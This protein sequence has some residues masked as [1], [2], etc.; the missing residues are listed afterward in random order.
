MPPKTP[1][2]PSPP[3]ASEPAPEPAPLR[4]LLQKLLEN[5]SLLR[6]VAG[7][8]VLL[9]AVIGWAVFSGGSAD[10][11]DED[12][13]EE[14][15]AEDSD[16]GSGDGK[17][18]VTQSSSSFHGLPLLPQQFKTVT[19]RV[20]TPEPGFFVLVDG[21]PARKKTGDKLITPCELSLTEGEH[22]LTVVK[23]G[24]KDSTNQVLAID[25][26]E[27]EFT[28]TFEPFAVASGYFASQFAL[29]EVG[30]EIPL[31]FLNTEG[32]VLDPFVTPDGLSIWFGGDRQGKRGVYVARRE[33]VL[34]RF[35]DPELLVATQVSQLPSS[36]S[37]TG[38]EL[39]VVYT[40]ADEARIW[41]V[42]RVSKEV[43]FSERKLL[44]FSDREE[45]R[46]RSAQILASGKTLYC[47]RERQG[48][49]RPIVTS[50]SSLEQKFSKKWKIARM[51]GSH[52]CLS[53][54]GLRQFVFDGTVLSRSSRR[55]IGDQFSPPEPIAELSLEHYTHRPEYRQIFVSDDEQWMYFTDD[56]VRLGNLYAVRISKGP[57]WGFVARGK[58]IPQ[59]EP[60]VA[61]TDSPDNATD[62]EMPADVPK[63]P[64]AKAEPPVDP[65]TRP[66]PYAELRAKVD[67]LLAV[68]NVEEAIKLVTAAQADP[69][70]KEDAEPLKWD[71]EDI[72]LV[73]GFWK[74]VTDVLG[75]MKDGDPIRIGP[76]QMAFKSFADGKINT[77]VNG[78]AFS[79][80]LREMNPSDVVALADRAID[81]SS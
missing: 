31:I 75:K 11:D 76:L 52:P 64:A 2:R 15:F 10:H 38:D 60:E 16:S 51:P 37:V 28:P 68:S 27:F 67:A 58:S 77:D 25:G 49:M 5:R 44:L 14:T 9:L 53:S 42:T 62:G 71:A 46:W 12:E 32:K 54:D 35:G 55:K 30:E 81:K 59:K 6:G 20:Y 78:Q 45:D 17:S 72:R 50:R 47:A 7:G 33:S 66:L 41:S 22:S 36:P 34:D 4:L 24:F 43:G 40:I 18:R 79:K 13:L 57:G 3:P 23:K 74:E 70:F 69:K 80:E 63:K 29:A 1:R 39:Q 19:C 61:D 73:Q 26:R 21:E 48:T 8:I 56:P 65:R